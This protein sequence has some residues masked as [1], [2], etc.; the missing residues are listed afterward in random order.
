MTVSFHKNSDND[1]LY[2]PIQLDG[3]GIKEIVSASECSFR[4]TTF[5][6]K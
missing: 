3:R 4:K 1:R 5:N 6:P 2:M